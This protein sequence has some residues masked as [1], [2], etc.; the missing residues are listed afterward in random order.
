[1]GEHILKKKKQQKIL[2]IYSHRLKSLGLPQNL[3]SPFFFFKDIHFGVYIDVY[4]CTSAYTSVCMQRP[5]EN[6][7]VF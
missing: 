2:K 6:N 3:C 4:K 1:M 5:E 7:V